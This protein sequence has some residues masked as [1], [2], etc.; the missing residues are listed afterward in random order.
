MNDDWNRPLAAGKVED[1]A[2]ISFK[3]LLLPPASGVMRWCWTWC[4]KWTHFPFEH[5]VYQIFVILSFLL[6]SLLTTPFQCV[7]LI[8]TV[9][10]VCLHT[11]NGG[12]PKAWVLIGPYLNS[13]TFQLHGLCFGMYNFTVTKANS[14]YF[15]RE[16]EAFPQPFLKT[17]WLW[18]ALIPPDL[19]GDT[20]RKQ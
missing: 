8:V 2:M 5:T 20:C 11:L 10:P 6:P 16:H 7:V 14:L 9:C 1:T 18:W 4:K 3:L 19:I 15:V 13:C 12:S 17:C